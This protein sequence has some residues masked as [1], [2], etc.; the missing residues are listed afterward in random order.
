MLSFIQWL[1]ESRFKQKR[2]ERNGKQS[3]YQRGRE[4]GVIYQQGEV[5]RPD[6][7]VQSINIHVFSE[8]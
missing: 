4:G 3:N 6:Q 5:D 8:P 2:K 7:E 1:G